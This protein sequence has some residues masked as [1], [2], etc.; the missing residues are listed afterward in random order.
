M[1]GKQMDREQFLD[2][3]E[4]FEKSLEEIC[5][6]SYKAGKNSTLSSEEIT[7]II[8]RSEEK[9]AEYDD[10]IKQLSAGQKASIE[11]CEDDVDDLKGY[12]LKLKENL[13]KQNSK[14]GK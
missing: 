10:A 3:S 12:L 14:K 13:H 1:V 11:E 7:D 4:H 8:K 9:I 2:F 6:E 5:V